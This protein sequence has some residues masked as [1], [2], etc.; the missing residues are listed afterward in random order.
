MN[1][2]RIA[3]IQSNYIPWKGYFDIINIVGE[4]V[5]FDDVQYTRRD[6]RNRN[7]IK[8]DKGT[9]WLTIPV[10]I[11]GNYNQK[12]NEAKIADDNWGKKHWLTIVHNYLK[13][14]YF[15]AY[16]DIFEELYCSISEKFLS[17]INYKFIKTINNVLGITTKLT[18]S[19]DY[20]LQ[21]GRVERLIGI[22]KASGATEYISGPAA[23]N[24]IKEELFSRENIKLT[25][26]DYSDYPEYNQLY[27]PFEHN[28]SII[29]LIFNEG[30]NAIKFMKS[31]TR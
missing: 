23:R 2:K 11:K 19:S 29:D 18:W 8:T 15:K 12:I 30:P 27:P 5:L 22:C 13:A 25:W 21:E 26:M 28:V 3:I 7:K 9:E 6:W 16:K 1:Q 20:A 17:K 31:F 24:Y 10:D 4:F 14:K